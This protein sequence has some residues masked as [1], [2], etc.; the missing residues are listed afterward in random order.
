ME[1]GKMRIR[2]LPNANS[3]LAWALVV[4]VAALLV[5]PACSINVKKDKAGEDKKVDIETPV[6]GIHVSKDADVRDIGL[7]VYPGAR[8]KQKEA[9][10][11]EKSANVNISSG[12]FGLRVVAIEY[13]SDDSPE[14]LIAYYKDQ[15][16]RYGDVLECHT[17]RHGADLTVNPTRHDSDGSRQ[18]KCDGDNSGNTVEL[19]VGTED[20]Q[21]IVAVEPRDKGTDFALVFVQLRGKD[22]I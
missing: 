13:E 9:K 19:K 17:H 18:V 14:K 10:G 1:V 22:T 5:L 3:Q 12:L 15:L 7:P 11:E 2:S 8:V 20:N 21:H 6:G 4:A 16:K